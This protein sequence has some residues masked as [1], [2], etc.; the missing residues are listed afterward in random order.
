MNE[1]TTETTQAWTDASSQK[2][3]KTVGAGSANE[4]PKETAPVHFDFDFTTENVPN[5]DVL[6]PGLRQSGYTIERA[7]GDLVDDP[8][9]AG[10]ETVVITLDQAGDEWTLM[11]ADDGRGMDRD[12]LDQMMRLGSRGERDYQNDLGTFGIGSSRASLA[13]GRLQHVVTSDGNGFWSAAADLD[14]ALASKT[15]AKHL[16]EARPAEQEL[17]RRAWQRWNLPT[18]RTGTL[19]R[20]SKCDTLGRVNSATAVDVLRRYLGQTYREW[21]GGGTTFFVNGQPVEAIDPLERQNPATLVL[22]DEVVDYSYPKNHWRAGQ[23]ESIGVSLV[24]LPDQGSADLNRARG[25]TPERS[26]LYLLR[27]GREIVEHATLNLFPRQTA[28]N[29]FRGELRFPASMDSDLGLTFLKTAWEPR[30]APALKEKLDQVLRPYLR[31]AVRFS[32]YAPSG[33]V[34]DIS[35]EEAA[36][37]IAHR[38]RF[39]RRPPVL[40]PVVPPEGTNAA[41]PLGSVHLWVR[42]PP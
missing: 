1:R 12:T 35:H 31:Q 14:E 32:A 5:A 41:P 2:R 24:Q 7:I 6:L 13:L 23:T 3:R 9:D 16:A 4:G 36:S 19:V 22:F 21:L 25:Y 39:L 8:L 11:I 17:F 30:I 40:V 20:V 15:F 34:D 27:N 28:Y 33:L 38:A 42:L 29:R 10:A 37:A 18:P 26:G